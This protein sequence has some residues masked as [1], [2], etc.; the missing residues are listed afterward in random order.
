MLLVSRESFQAY[1]VWSGTESKQ[2]LLIGVETGR[3]GLYAYGGLAPS[4]GP[5]SG[6]SR[7]LLA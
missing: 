4:P 2:T 7:S 3:G 5:S 1:L 6:R